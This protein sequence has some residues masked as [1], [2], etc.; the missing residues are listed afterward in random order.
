GFTADEREFIRHSAT[1]LWRR[2][3]DHRS[4]WS[5]PEAGGARRPSGSCFAAWQTTKYDGLP[6]RRRFYPIWGSGAG[7]RCVGRMRRRRTPPSR[8][9]IPLATYVA[10]INTK[11]GWA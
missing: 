2:G 9:R 10:A 3:A 4:L 1:L 5:A 7:D 11:T 8:V 6:H